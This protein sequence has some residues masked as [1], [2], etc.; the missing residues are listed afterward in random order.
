[1]SSIRSRVHSRKSV[2]TWSLRERAVCSRPAAGPI[3]SASRLSMF[4][5][6]SSSDRLN[7]NLPD[8]ISDKIVSRPRTILLASAAVIMP[9]FASISAWA[10]LAAMSCR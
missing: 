9:C 2:A 8:P 3:I 6:M 1:M 4:I 5:W 7:L 10:L